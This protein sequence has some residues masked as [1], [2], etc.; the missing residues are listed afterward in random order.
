MKCSLLRLPVLAVALS[1]ISGCSPLSAFNP[2]PKQNIFDPKA[3]VPPDFLFTRY[4]PFNRWLDQ[5]VVVQIYD[6]PLVEVFEQP[7]LRGL[8]YRFVTRPDPNIRVTVDRVALTR[9][10]LLWSIAQDHQLHMTPRFS[11]DGGP[12]VV[13][14]RS[15]HLT[16]QEAAETRLRGG[17]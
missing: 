16:L 17:N 12:A 9:R 13:E 6:V 1:L 10:Q 14:I 3:V 11:A 7:A 15:R 5:P 2:R 4:E 8:R